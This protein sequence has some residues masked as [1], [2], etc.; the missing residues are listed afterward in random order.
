MLVS[1]ELEPSWLLTW[2]YSRY[3]VH[4]NC[5]ISESRTHLQRTVAS[6]PR[7]QCPACKN[8][9]TEQWSPGK[10]LKIRMENTA[11]T[12]ARFDELQSC[13]NSIYGLNVT[14]F[15]NFPV[16]IN[17]GQTS[18]L[19]YCQ[20]KN[21]RSATFLSQCKSPT[22]KVSRFSTSALEISVPSQ[23]PDSIPYYR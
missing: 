10:R 6:F 1:A 22:V 12:H 23:A 17:P 2:E 4:V 13:T 8:K 18:H 15:A 21:Q 16:F 14:R 5:M 3:T 20:A 7:L 9:S 11:S 19:K